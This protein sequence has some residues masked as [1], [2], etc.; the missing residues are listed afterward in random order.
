M[1]A[2]SSLHGHNSSSGISK[3]SLDPSVIPLR[4]ASVNIHRIPVI[5]ELLRPLESVVY[6]STK[7][8]GA[9]GVGC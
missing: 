2:N 9:I 7:L 4:S 3:T 6:C 5:T 8:L 1:S